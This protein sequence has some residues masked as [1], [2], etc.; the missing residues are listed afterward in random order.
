M[1]TNAE[2]RMRKTCKRC[3][4]KVKMILQFQQAISVQYQQLYTDLYFMFNFS[5]PKK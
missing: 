2:M 4:R 5:K 1:A 3:K